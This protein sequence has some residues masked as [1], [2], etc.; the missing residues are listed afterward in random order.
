MDGIVYGHNPGGGVAR[1]WTEVLTTL[2]QLNQSLHFDIVIPKGAHPPAG[3]SGRITGRL[4]TAWAVSRADLIHTS[5]YTRWPRI[6]K[7]SI[8]TVY[9]YI[10][11]SFPL[12][13]PNGA[14]FVSRQM[15]AI[16]QASAIIAISETSRLLTIELAKVD[17]A[18]I[19][20]AYPAV[21][22]PFSQPLPDASAIQEFRRT[23]TQGAPYL[24]HV[25]GR[26]NYKNFQTIL[27]GY[28]LAAQS[29][30]RH[31]LIL[32]G[33][34]A[35]TVEELNCIIAAGVLSRVHFYPSIGD[36]ELKLAYSGADAMVHA[37]LMEGFGIPVIESLACGTGVIL[38]DI[39]IYREIAEGR[40]TFI[41]S[42]N[43]EAWSDA[44]SRNMPI[45][46]SWRN[47]VLSQYTWK[48]TTDMHLQAYESVLQ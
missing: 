13:H 26:K 22:A 38:S 41:E 31:L 44:M 2:S 5:Y 29:T 36:A 1:Y 45:S 15:E 10:D 42:N 46:P 17:P 19:F 6:K 34:R 32:G 20:V 35:L 40:A 4:A 3:I 23:H 24:L 27:K 8:V 30:D 7:P 25:G 39:P 43:I 18:R 28:C 48:K 14:G 12:L 37:S 47:E 33:E 9:D 16:Q 21:S 11:A